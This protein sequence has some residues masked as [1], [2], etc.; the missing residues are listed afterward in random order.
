MDGNIKSAS[1]DPHLIDLCL[2]FEIMRQYMNSLKRA[3]D[4]LTNKFL[5][6][7]SHEHDKRIDKNKTY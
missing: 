1:L 4:I 6:F 7:I 2:A 5:E 3:F